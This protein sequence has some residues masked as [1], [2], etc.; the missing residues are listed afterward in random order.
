MPGAD[1]KDEKS[2]VGG[3]IDFLPT[4]LNLMGL[5]NEKGIMFGND[6]NNSKNGFVAE[7][8]YVLKGSFINDDNIFVMS[9]DGI[10]KNSTAWDIN[11]REPVDLEKSREDYERAIKEINQSDYILQNN[12]LEKIINKE[13]PQEE[14][15]HE[16]KPL[17][18]KELIAHGG[19]SIEGL[20]Y[21]NSREALDK[22][23]KNGFRFMEVD[24]E[25]TTDEQLVAIHSWDGFVTKFFLKEAKQYSYEEFISFEMIN[26]WQQLT[27]EIIAQWL[28]EHKDAYIITD[29]KKRN[30]EGLKVISEK[31]PDIQD[32]I[33]PQ[34]YLMEEYSQ[35]QSLG[36]K[37]IILTLYASNYTDEEII[38]FGRRQKLLAITMPLYRGY[39]ELP[40]KLNRENVF[41][42][43]HTIN[44][45]EIRDELLENGVNGF[46]TD[47]FIPDN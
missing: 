47:D 31:Y 32:Q 4:I 1:I 24:F 28:R 6:L 44:D 18:A 20:T 34:I 7:Q 16:L 27:P 15:I 43:V 23:Y 3:Q 46:Y 22:S 11:T 8:T 9:R 2:I 25:W 35:A 39:T 42:Y 21:T 33:I 17:E 26:D 41:V 40:S 29:I 5:R 36:Y 19:G 38:D 37:N 14:S 10:Y 12:L 30:I 13:E 45:K